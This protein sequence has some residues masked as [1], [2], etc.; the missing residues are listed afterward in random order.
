MKFRILVAT[1]IAARGLDIPHIEHVINYDLPQCPEDYIHRIGRTGRNGSEGSAVCL[2]S[3]DDG[4]KWRAIHRL[5]HPNEAPPQ[6]PRSAAGEKPRSY[7]GKKPFGGAK[8]R[9]K[10]NGNSSGGSNSSGASKP[11]NNKRFNRFPKR[12]SA[13][14]AAA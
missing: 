12:S 3:P 9:G 8:P 11:G 6:M 7:G 14:K 13:P 10:S 5:M 2:I 4:L 1:D